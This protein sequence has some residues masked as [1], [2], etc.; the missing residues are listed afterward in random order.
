MQQ[1]RSILLVHVV[2]HWCTMYLIGVHCIVHRSI[3]FVLH[4]GTNTDEA[5]AQVYTLFTPSKI[6]GNGVGNLFPFTSVVI[7]FSAVDPLC[8]PRAPGLA[9][10]INLL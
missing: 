8:V 1:Q 5:S 3:V 10:P 2:V 9:S 4:R 6:W 7:F